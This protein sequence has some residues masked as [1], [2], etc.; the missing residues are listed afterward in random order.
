MAAP[1]ILRVAFDSGCTDGDPGNGRLRFDSPKLSKAKFLFINARDA[2]DAVLDELVPTWRLGDVVVIE[3]TGNDVNRMVAW[4]IGDVYHRG[5]Y[6]KV[7][8]A[9][10]SVYG[11]FAAHDELLVHHH[12]NVAE[13]DPAAGAIGA[14]GIAPLPS[15]APITKQ[16]SSPLAPMA[17]M[18][19][20]EQDVVPLA[21]GAPHST[22]VPRQ[23]PLAPL[24][25]AQADKTAELEAEV[26]EL[27]AI[28][29][30]MVNDQTELHVVV[31]ARG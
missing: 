23:P 16:I 5:G 24:A 10:R 3:R 18:A 8:L 17:P 1:A 21:A 13:V 22:D 26:A 27:R 6:W 30:E 15:L 28:L 20:P 31:G 29:K 25:P 4:V 12:A 11:S 19:P 9:V 14:A 7:P 2:Q